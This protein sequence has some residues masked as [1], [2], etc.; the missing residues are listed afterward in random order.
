MFFV[1]DLNGH[2]Q[3]WYPDGDTNAEGVLIDNLFSDQ[4]LSQLTQPTNLTAS[5]HV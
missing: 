3:I 2:S 4:N 5:R 1:D